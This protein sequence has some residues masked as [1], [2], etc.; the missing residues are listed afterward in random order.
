MKMEDF[1]GNSAGEVLRDVLNGAFSG[2]VGDMELTKDGAHVVIPD[3][4]GRWL[5]SIR[6]IPALEE[7]KAVEIKESA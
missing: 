1:M 7:S 2:L 4:G 6:R 5:L 3:E